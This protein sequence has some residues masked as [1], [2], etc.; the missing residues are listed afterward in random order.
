MYIR[1]VEIRENIRTGE[2]AV[3][4]VVLLQKDDRVRGEVH[5]VVKARFRLG[6]G[7][8]PGKLTASHRVKIR[9]GVLCQ[10]PGQSKQ[11][12]HPSQHL[13]GEV[14]H[15]GHPFDRNQFCIMR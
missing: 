7:R 14:E 2:R 4:F 3:G 9:R 15:E 13:S 1:N 10:R 11:R 8:I 6:Q 5:A 12:Q